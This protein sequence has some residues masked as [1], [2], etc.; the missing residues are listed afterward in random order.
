MLRP[1]VILGLIAAAFTTVAFIPQ[2]VKT[3]QTRHTADISFWMYLLLNIGVLL[4][5]VYGILLGDLALILANGITV[6]WTL[7]IL[8]LKIKNG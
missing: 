2:A 1:V 5:L 8:F 4:W 7:A 6:I 3:L